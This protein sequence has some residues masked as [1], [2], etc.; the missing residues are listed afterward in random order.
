[1]NVYS[2]RLPVGE[3]EITTSIRRYDHRDRVASITDEGVLRSA[4]GTVALTCK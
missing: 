3:V 4:T 2:A 1:M